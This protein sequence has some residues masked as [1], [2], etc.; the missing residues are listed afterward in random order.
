MFAKC[1]GCIYY[2]LLY[3][4]LLR[5]GSVEE[6][7][8]IAAGLAMVPGTSHTNGEYL[9]A[10]VQWSLF[11]ELGVVATPEQVAKSSPSG[12]LFKSALERLAA[13][14][15]VGVSERAAGAEYLFLACDKGHRDG[16]DHF[17]KIICFWDESKQS[18][19]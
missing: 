5:V 2:T 8:K 10:A 13:S 11:C 7:N 16:V 4:A 12:N 3:Y 14:C 6:Q 9:V 18:A 17:V 19:D 15:L 1:F